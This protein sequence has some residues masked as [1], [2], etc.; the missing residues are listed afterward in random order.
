[1]KWG[2]YHAETHSSGVTRFRLLCG[3]FYSARLKKCAFFYWRKKP[4][5]TKYRPG[6]REFY[7]DG[8]DPW[9]NSYCKRV[10][11]MK[12]E[13]QEPTVSVTQISVFGVVLGTF[14]FPSIYPFYF[15]KI[16]KG[17]WQGRQPENSFW[18]WVDVTIDVDPQG[19]YCICYE[20]RSWN[21]VLPLS[22]E[23]REMHRII[24]IRYRQ[25]PCYC[26]CNCASWSSLLL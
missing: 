8:M 24:E 2:R 25:C 3:A 19:F 4:R 15:V 22:R 1:M 9:C 17:M 20:Q 21:N 26:I 10:Y 23:E 18:L 14:L 11:L 12:G 5:S 13:Y 7:N 6:A 16:R